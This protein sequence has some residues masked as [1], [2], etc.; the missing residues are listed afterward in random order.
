MKTLVVIPAYNEEKT[1]GD[2]I[3]QVNEYVREGIVHKIVVVDDCSQDKTADIARALQVDVISHVIN[4][5]Y[6]AA[7]QTG[8]KVAVEE[9][10]DYVIQIDADGQHDPKY[11]PLFTETM[12]EGDYD[13]ILGSRFLNK[14]YKEYVFTRIVG[15]KFFTLIVNALGSV[16]LTDITSGY[17]MYRVS[18][19]TKVG[20]PP[21]RHPAVEQMLEIS[22]KKMKIKEISIEMPVRKKG[23]SHLNV[24]TYILYPFRVLETLFTVVFFRRE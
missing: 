18:A 7:Q 9:H 13:I 17:K 2:V 23:E 20:R 6:G 1:I 5:G 8:L 4:R 24:K 3:T 16:A 11:I 21:D 19:L 12:K 10:F 22:R 14:S 15:I